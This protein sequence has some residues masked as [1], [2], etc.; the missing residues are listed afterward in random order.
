MAS[1]YS[2]N[3]AKSFMNAYMILQSLLAAFFCTC[4]LG[5]PVQVTFGDAGGIG[6]ARGV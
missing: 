4:P 6:F 3:S 5:F 2:A 1:D